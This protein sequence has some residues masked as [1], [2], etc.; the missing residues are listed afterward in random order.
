MHKQLKVLGFAVSLLVGGADFAVAEGE[1]PYREPAR[2]YLRQFRV[3][4]AKTFVLEGF[5][6]EGGLAARSVE[7]LE[8]EVE[9]GG[10]VERTIAGRR[11]SLRGLTA[12]P[13]DK[14]VYN[15]VQSWN[16][17]DAARDY[18]E[19]VYNRRAS[20]ILCKTL[21]L[22]PADDETIPASCFVLV[23]GTGE[24]FKTV[25]DDDSMVFLGLAAIG[26]TKDGR[27]RR[28]DLERSQS[29][30]RSMGFQNAD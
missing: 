2:N 25:N 20:V 8:E 21:V 7:K 9:I 18:A 13:T 11:F 15:R 14:V 1:D 5:D 3:E 24:P 23:G 16:C 4:G 17:V 27:S 30:S 28:P 6:A 26:R 10:P 22:T 19:A 12:C 29:L